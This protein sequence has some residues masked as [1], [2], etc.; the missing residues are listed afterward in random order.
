MRTLACLDKMVITGVKRSR[1]Q[2]HTGTYIPI[3]LGA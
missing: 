2:T 1:G 3:L